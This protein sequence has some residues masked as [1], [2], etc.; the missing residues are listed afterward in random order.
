MN[1]EFFQKVQE[2]LAAERLGAY[3]LKDNADE[4]T[5]LSRYLLNMALCESLYSPLQLSEV[6]LR[7]AI[8]N[9]LTRR[10]G[11]DQWFEQLDLTTWQKDKI[12]EAKAS[13]VERKKQLTPGRIVAELTFG[14][15]TGFFNN[16]HSRTGLGPFILK[17]V[18]ERAP[19]ELKGIKKMDKQWR[20]IR[21]LR[22]R[23]FHHERIIHWE[24]LDE[25]HSRLLEIIG[26][27]S[28]ELCEMAHALDR[29]KSIRKAGLT[30]W[31]EK[32][33]SH[34]PNDSFAPPFG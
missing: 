10:A 20:K 8:H 21:D 28:P 22:N 23:V 25:K 27:I 7:N 11:N 18:F 1:S 12:E 30:P 13:L 2:G 34:W 4:L 29:Y 9:A 6:A 31:A 14:F 17:D 26:W 33:R 19:D 32:I 24:D 5:T 16:A 15:W 3:R